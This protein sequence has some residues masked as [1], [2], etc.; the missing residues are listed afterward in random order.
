MVQ[1][2]GNASPPILLYP[3]SQERALVNA[4]RRAADSGRTLLLEPGTHFTARGQKNTIEIGALGLEIGRAQS[5]T[6]TIITRFLH[7]VGSARR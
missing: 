1:R 3:S 5:A 7:S 2:S 6:K 4:I